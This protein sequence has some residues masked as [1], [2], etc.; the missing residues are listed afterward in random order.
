M[1]TVQI[2]IDQNGHAPEV[3]DLDLSLDTMTMR[4][5]VRLE[6]ALGSER[7]DALVRTGFGGELSPRVIQAVVYAKLKTVRPDVELDS[8]DLELDDLASALESDL[9]KEE[10]SAGGSNG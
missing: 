2:R 4:E 7:F 8:F 5:S 3:L 6:E 10:P 1:A 9:P